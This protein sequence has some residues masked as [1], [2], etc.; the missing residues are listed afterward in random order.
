MQEMLQ[1][2]LQLRVHLVQLHINTVPII[3]YSSAHLDRIAI[4]IMT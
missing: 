2:K 3:F 4:I 1:L